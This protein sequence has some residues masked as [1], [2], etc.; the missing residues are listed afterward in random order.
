MKGSMHLHPI[1]K[2][3]ESRELKVLDQ[4]GLYNETVSKDI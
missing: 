1:T 4:P 2:E 3:A